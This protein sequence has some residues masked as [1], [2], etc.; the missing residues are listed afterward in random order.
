MNMNQRGFS[1]I[2]LMVVIAIVASLSAGGLHGWHLWRQ[3]VQL[4]QTTQQ[5]T[6]F[7]SRLRNE[8]NWNNQT[9]LLTLRQSGKSW[10]LTSRAAPE[11]CSAERRL[12]FMPEFGDIALE[13]MTAGLGF[14][15]VRDTAWP[16]H[17]ILKS[18]AGRWKVTLSV[19]GRVRL[20][21]MSGGKP[22]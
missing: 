13:E 22:C 17:I 9:H 5:L 7:L 4:W 15:G 20:C 14:Y 10:C 16:G 1:L 6:H 2:E 11:S 21:E 12:A 8:A 18:P 3:K 19:W